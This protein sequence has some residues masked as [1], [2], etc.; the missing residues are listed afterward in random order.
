V[1]I[2][3]L[4]FTTLAFLEMSG[5]IEHYTLTIFPHHDENGHII[6][7]S[8]NVLYVCSI[9]GLQFILLLLTAYFTTSIT[10]RLHTQEHNSRTA[11]QRLRSVLQAS[12]AGYIIL[13]NQ[14]R[15]LWMNGQ[16]REWLGL[17]DHVS[18]TAPN[19]LY[20]WLGGDKGAA[21]KTFKDGRV[22][23]TERQFIRSN[24]DKHIFHITVAPIIETNG[25]VSQVVE[26]VQDVT[27][28]KQLQTEMMHSSKM[29]A[30]GV[31]AAGV[32]HEIGNP[33]A[34]ISTRLRLLKEQNDATFLQESIEL[35]E[36]EIKRISNILHSVSRIAQPSKSNWSSCDI[37]SIVQET[38]NILKF[39]KGIKQCRIESDLCSVMPQTRGSRDELLQVFLNLGL[40]ALDKMPDGG[41]LS[42]KT[43]AEKNIIRISFSDTGEGM[44]DETISKIFTPFFSTKQQGLGLGL[45]IANNII[46]AHSGNITVKSKIGAGSVITVILPVSST[47]KPFNT[48]NIESK[49]F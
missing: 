4:F 39:D 42:I 14:L 17:T 36:K 26:L 43:A 32:A 48:T 5:L 6:H 34:S 13:D 46:N 11:G 29:T 15:P 19:K 20:K 40:N 18:D 44:T 49:G 9:V 22:H 33:L 38:I 2:A 28:Q 7:A 24:G 27:Q 45:Y 1:V 37:N 25:N 47:L 16:I 41:T 21:S 3:S 8:N 10:E 23:V 31:M 35:L 30:L 12:G